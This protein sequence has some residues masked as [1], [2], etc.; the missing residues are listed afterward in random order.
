MSLAA[1]FTP[2][3]RAITNV[4]QALQAVVTTSEN[5]GYNSNEWVRLIVPGAYGMDLDYIQTFITVTSNTQFTTTLDTTAQ[6]P[7][8]T[9]GG[10][11]NFPAFTA[12]QVVPISQLS[13][14]IDP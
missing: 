5:H 4:T 3:R 7:F 14:V 10:V 6:L 8:V 1:N 13:T 11:P 9:P 2:V 12:A